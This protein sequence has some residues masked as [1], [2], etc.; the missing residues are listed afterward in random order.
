MLTTKSVWT[1]IR[2]KQ[3][4][5]TILL[6]LVY[7]IMLAAFW[8]ADYFDSDEGEIFLG[9]YSVAHGLLV[10]KD[11]AAQHMP[12]M[13]YIAA[14]FSLFG[15][16]SY[17]EFR[18]CFYFLMAL[19]YGIIYYRYRKHFDKKILIIYPVIYISLFCRMW[20]GHTVVSEQFQAIGMVILFLELLLFEK[21][22]EVK[23]NNCI[24]ISLAIFISFGSA[25]IS[26]FAIFIVFLTVL[27][28]KVVHYKKEQIGLISGT[29]LFIKSF[30]KL[31]AIVAAPFLVLIIFYAVTGTL[32]DFFNWAYTLNR[33]I[34]PKYLQ[35]VVGV[36]YGD[37]IF[38]SVFASVNNI[39]C[40]FMPADLS[41]NSSS[42]V[43]FLSLIGVIYFLLNIQREK[44]NTI[45]TVGTAL[46][47]I[48]CA[49][50]AMFN[51]WSNF[52]GLPAV[53]MVSIMDAFVLIDIAKKIKASLAKQTVLVAVCI[54]FCSSYLN[55]FPRLFTFPIGQSQEPELN[56]YP[57]IIDL[58]ADNEEIVGNALFNNSWIFEANVLQAPVSAASAWYWENGGDE[59]MKK[60]DED[61]PRIFIYL[62][63]WS[64]WSFPISDYAPDLVLFIDQN[65]KSLSILNYPMLYV[66]NDYYDEAIEKILDDYKKTETPVPMLF[67]SELYDLYGQPSRSIMF[68]TDTF[69][70]DE[71][72]INFAGWAFCE[73]EGK[74]FDELYV[75]FGDKVKAM[76]YCNGERSDVADSFSNDEIKNCG[77]GITLAN[78]YTE[79]EMS[80]IKILGVCNGRLYEA[81][82]K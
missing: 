27:I 50:R 23:L 14:V 21:K 40:D 29:Q 9:G 74:V 47:F 65:Y 38:E 7:F 3:M 25:F 75:S 17:L 1:K 68:A 81:V 76:D 64:L 2:E 44:K 31:I 46:S 51:G 39:L 82:I 11:F 37:N 72:T 57:Y 41:L 42:L 45:L 6:I 43:F 69:D 18:M 71:N 80:D 59:Q 16:K 33:E 12:V 49:S 73:E 55:V 22:G 32:D 52:H 15:V 56:S 28:M 20:M 63:N 60:Y 54:I 77:F 13:Y 34:Y 5:S 66:R 24:A 62:P 48:F 70:C 4:I 78:V 30:W 26:I 61:P 35:S 58:I 36:K 8:N 67:A 53:A 79:E 19:S 10:Y